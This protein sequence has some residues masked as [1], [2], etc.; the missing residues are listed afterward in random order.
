MRRQPQAPT[1]TARAWMPWPGSPTRRTNCSSSVTVT[2]AGSGPDLPEPPDLIVSE[3]SESDTNPI[4]GST[5]TLSA[6]VLNIGHGAAA[7]TTLRYYQS[8]D[9]TIT[10]ADTVVGTAAVA[11]LAAGGKQQRVGGDQCAVNLRHLLLRRVRGCRGRGVRHD[12]QL[13][14]VGHGHGRRERARPTGASRPDRGRGLGER[15]QPDCGFNVDPLGDGIEYRRG[16]RRG[17]DAALLPIDGRHNHHSGYGGRHGRGGGPRRRGSSS[18]SVE[19]SAPSTSGT[20]YYGACV[21]AVAEES[22]TTNNCSSSTSVTVA[23]SLVVTAFSV[24]DTNPIAGSTLTLS[25]TVRNNSD[26]TIVDVLVR[27]GFIRAGYGNETPATTRIAV[28][29]ASESID[30]SVVVRVP[31][32]GTYEFYV[33]VV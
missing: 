11:G 32:P 24:S 22:D 19:I 26:S 31:S 4:A 17:H 20:Y 6:T 27:Y 2:V 29:A 15:H 3:V 5:L 7:A 14:V 13:L 12:E 9:A 28:L 18:E 23:G 1:T 30:D 33:Y 10:T 25:A 21:D 16:S 8:T